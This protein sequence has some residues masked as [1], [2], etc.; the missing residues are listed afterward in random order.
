ML[1]RYLLPSDARF[2]RLY[3]V[4]LIAAC[5]ERFDLDGFKACLAHSNDDPPEL[6]FNDF[7]EAFGHFEQ[8]KDSQYEMHPK[9]GRYVSD[10]RREERKG[11]RSEW[12]RCARMAD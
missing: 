9:Y 2:Y 4:P 1:L 8:D 3:A 7:E 5:P 11:R 10:K 12:S 6:S